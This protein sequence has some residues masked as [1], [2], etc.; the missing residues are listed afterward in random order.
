MK[1]MVRWSVMAALPLVAA[2]EAASAQVLGVPVYFNPRGGTGFGVAANAG[3]TSSDLAAVEGKAWALS[4]SFGLS[5]LRLTGTVATFN[6]DPAGDNQTAFGAMAEMRLFGG[7]LVPVAISAGAGVGANKTATAGMDDLE[8]HIPIGLAAALN[9]PLFPL[10]PW[11]AP[12]IQLDRRLVDDPATA[13]IDPAMES[14]TSFRVSAGVDFS[15]LLGLGVH[16]AVDWGKLP[17]KI[18]PNQNSTLTFG[19]GAH[20]N[21]SVPMM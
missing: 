17:K 11:V 16:A 6:P 5:R 7:G 9:L 8:V 10:K 19:V 14:A 1:R 3:V 18:D 4:G 12:R 20:F 15:L 13:A 2:S 21:F